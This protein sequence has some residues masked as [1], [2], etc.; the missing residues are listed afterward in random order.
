MY[1]IHLVLLDSE[2]WEA[3]MIE[4]CSLDGGDKTVLVETH[5][6]NQLFEKLKKKC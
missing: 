4:V 6:R 1:A 2:I 3:V 5:L